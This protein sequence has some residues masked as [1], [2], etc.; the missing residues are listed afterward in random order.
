MTEHEQDVAENMVGVIMAGGAGTRFWPASTQDRPKQFLSLFGEDSLLQQSYERL[1][2]F[3]PPERILV[4]TNSD[5]TGLVR[6]QLPQLPVENVIGEPMR[7][8]TAAA[9]ALASAICAHRHHDPVMAIVTADHLIQPVDE[10]RRTMLSAARGARDSGALYTFGIRPDHP[11]TGF[12]YLKLGTSRGKDDGV[13]HFELHGFVEKPDLER[14]KDYLASGQ[15]AWNSGMFVWRASAILDEL[16]RQLPT[17]LARV[18]DAVQHDGRPDFD[19]C[20]AQAFEPLEKI[21]IDF[22]V[23]EGAHDVRAV[24]AEFTWY[25]VGSFPALAD[26]L[27]TDEHG[28]AHRARLFSVDARDNIVFSEDDDEVVAILG[29]SDLVVVRAGKR[30][31]VAPRAR[32]EDIKALVAALDEDLR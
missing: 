5:F 29:A 11:A 2:S 21:S 23:M 22:G 1:A 24:R 25:D 3:L 4:L 13:E 17:H 16:E 19:D 14:A 9:I 20:L 28:N 7:R 26:H 10:F 27:P 6:L 15:Y 8:D 30:T 31:L 32:A 12:G 18:L